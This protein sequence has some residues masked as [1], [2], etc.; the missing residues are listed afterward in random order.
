M[1][2][3][4]HTY[5]TLKLLYLK[6]QKKCVYIICNTFLKLQQIN[7]NHICQKTTYKQH[8]LKFFKASNYRQKK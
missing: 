4:T 6:L 1:E 5:T 8:L 2:K 3:R 7:Y